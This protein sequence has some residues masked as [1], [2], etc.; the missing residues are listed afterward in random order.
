MNRKRAKALKQKSYNLVIDYVKDRLLTPE[1]TEG[2]SDK[3][4]LR[5]VPTH[6]YFRLARTLRVGILSQRWFYKQVKKN[7][8]VT[9]NELKKKAGIA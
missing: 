6:A 9:Y 4:L 5:A 1:Q 8:E 3:D 2:Y 7:P